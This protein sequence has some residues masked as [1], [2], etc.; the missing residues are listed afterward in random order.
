MRRMAFE[1]V[2]DRSGGKMAR[3]GKVLDRSVV[4]VREV[5]QA[6]KSLINSSIL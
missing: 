3:S 1:I 6:C 2:R 4:P 5:W